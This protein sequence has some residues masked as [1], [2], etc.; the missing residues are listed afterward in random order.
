MV[1]VL[2]SDPLAGQGLAVL[3][4]ARDVDVMEC[5]LL[6]RL[7][8]FLESRH[9]CSG[10]EYVLKSGRQH[11]LKRRGEPLLEEGALE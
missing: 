10:R 11:V 4:A 7:E 9:L 2:V 8:R 3:E 1:K 6:L 5:S